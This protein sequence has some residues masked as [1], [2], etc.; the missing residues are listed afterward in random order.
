M[1]SLI[2]RY[3]EPLPPWIHDIK[4]ALKRDIAES[5][6][7]ALSRAGDIQVMRQLILRFWPFVDVF[8]KLIRKG[9]SRLLKSELS[10]QVKNPSYQRVKDFVNI[11]LL[12]HQTLSDIEK[13]EKSHRSLWLN[14]ATSLG[15]AYD[16]LEI[17][18]LSEVR[19]IIVSV[20]ESGD[21]FGM[22]LRFAEVEMV[23]EAVSKDFL[24][25]E[26]FVSIVG[27]RGIRWFKEHANHADGMTHEELALRLA[28][29]F[30]DDRLDRNGVEMIVKNLTRL[31]IEAGEKCVELAA[32]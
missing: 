13:D 9:Y 2:E 16:D 20:G 14:T 23:A 15:F 11:L 32:L 30:N 19:A 7:A 22:F 3:N 1:S 31:F 28:F 21:A 26:R 8:P 25:S 10:K 4:V 18:P 5:R 24:A 17:E 12:A 29:A 27:A 6:F